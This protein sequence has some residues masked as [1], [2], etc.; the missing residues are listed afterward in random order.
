MDRCRT[1][2]WNKQKICV[3]QISRVAKGLK[4]V[5]LKYKYGMDGTVIQQVNQSIIY[6]GCII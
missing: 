3:Q 5:Y 4:P 6:F 2:K 1:I